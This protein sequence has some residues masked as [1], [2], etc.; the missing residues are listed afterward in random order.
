MRLSIGLLAAL[1]VLAGASVLPAQDVV[2]ERRVALTSGQDI[3]GGDIRQIFGTTLDACI[4][5]CLAETRCVA[6]TFNARSGACFPKSVAGTASPYSGA[7]SGPVIALSGAERN[8]GAARTTELA[9]FLTPDDLTQARSLAAAFAARHPAEGRALPTLRE[10]AEAARA[11]G[12]WQAAADLAA[13]GITLTDD[14]GDW[15]RYALLTRR[16]ALVPEAEDRWGGLQE[17]LSAAINAYLRAETPSA[18]AASLTEL[19]ATLEPMG[20]GR[21]M[22]PALRLAQTL[23]AR[24]ETAAALDEAIGKYGFRLTDTQIDTATDRPRIC[25]VFSEPLAPAGVDYAPFVRLPDPALS[26]EAAGQQLCIGGVRHGER[27]TLTFRR[28]LPSARGEVLRADTPLTA[29][30]RDRSPAAWFPGRAYVLPRTGEVA[31]PV[32]TVNAG[33]LDLVL[34]RVSDRAL[35]R[36]MQEQLFA[37]PL[38]PWRIEDFDAQLAQEIW[39]GTA[40]VPSPLNREITTRLPLAAA[41]PLE[42]GVYVLRAAVADAGDS[43]ASRPQQWFVISDIGV[44]TMTGADGLTVFAQSLGTAEP[45]AGAQV[46]LISQGNAVLAAAE[47]DDTGRAAFALPL[48]RGAGAGAPALLTLRRGEDLS[49]LSLTEP[50][51]DLSDRGVAGREAPPPIDVFLTTDR[52]V[53]RPGE[54]V[55]VTALARNDRA[56][57]ETGLPL[58]LRLTRPDGVEYMRQTGTDQGA[59][60]HVWAAPLGPDAARGLWRIDILAEADRPLTSRTFLVEDFL[61]ERIDVALTLGQ[62]PLRLG[63]VAEG[64]VAARYLFGPPAP[65]LAVEGEVRLR[66]AASL[67]DWPGYRFGLQDDPFAPRMAPLPSGLRTGPDGTLPLTLTLPPVDLPPARPL[68]AEVVLRVAEGSGRPVE[69]RTVA[70]VLPGTPVIGIRPATEGPVPEGGEARYDVIALD[71][72]LTRAALPVRWTLE[73]VETRYQWFNLDSAWNWQ[74][75]TTRAEVAQGEAQIPA[76]APLVLAPRVDWGHYE[77]RVEAADGTPVGTSIGFDAGWYGATEGSG[78]PDRLEVSLDRDVYNPGETA[79]FRISSREGGQA[80]VTVLANRVIASRVVTVPAGGAVVDLA[81]TEDWG[82][83]AYVTASLLRPLDRAAGHNPARAMGLAHAAIA[84]GEKRILARFDMPASADP[85]GPMEAVLRVDGAA[86]GTY[87]TIAAVDLGILNLTGFTP[88]DPEGHYFGQQRLGVGIRDIYGRLIDGLSGALGTIRSGGDAGAQA[89]LQGEPPA[90]APVSFFSGPLPVE[91][92]VVRTGF[93]LPAFNGTVRLMAVIWSE[94]GV[95][96]ATADVTVRDPV[97]VEASAARV[98]APGDESRLLLRFTHAAGAAGHMPLSV[99]ASGL[100]LSSLVP[101]G[102]E[103]AEGGTAEVTLPFSASEQGWARIN[104]ALTTP[105]GRTLSQEVAIPV[106][107]NDPPVSE[108]RRIALDPGQTLRFDRDVFANYVPGTGSA[109]LAAGPQARLD[110]PGLL[111]LLADYPYACT[112]QTASR[113]LPLLYFTET[114]SQMG[115]PP[116]EDAARQAVARI[117]ANQSANGSFGLWQAGSGDLWL[118]AY[119]TDVLLRTKEQGGAVPERALTSALDN[120]RNQLS[121]APDF[122]ARGGPWAYAML[123]LTRAGRAPVDDL[124]YY[125]DVKAAAFDTPL[126]AAQL[127]AALA[128]TGDQSRADRLFAQAGEMAL[129]RLGAPGN[130][131]GRDDYGSDRRDA[132]GMVALAAEAGS[133]AAP[134]DRIVARLGEDATGTA[135]TQ[136]AAWTLLVAHA[137]SA[138]TSGDITVNGAP[139]AGS[140]VQALS[141]DEAATPVTVSNNGGTASLLTLTTFGVPAV[142]EP[143]GGQGYAITRRYTT[144]S[145]E[146]VNGPLAPGTRLVAVI[147]VTPT[148]TVPARLV[149]DDPLPGGLEIDN[150][151]L[152]RAG[153]LSQL[154]WLQPTETVAHAEFRE[155]R[156]VAQ[157][158]S[159]GVEVLRLAYILRAVTPGRYHHPAASV[160]DMYRPDYRAVTDSGTIEVAP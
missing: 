63:A 153:D 67:A 145:G 27:Y 133:R 137:L 150:P 136:E 35:V 71:P 62:A 42:P 127:G 115:L 44:T 7:I 113:L 38:P 119:A 9:A 134:L 16:A 33:R 72:A 3:P 154:D 155:D 19:A 26:V 53:Y 20:R 54:T 142:A 78:T 106:R 143:A 86:P 99:T 96:Q 75:V 4:R 104:V 14:S 25:A 51:F 85:R 55:N 34:S 56:A 28:G 5:A 149:I 47:T 57:A 18:R 60:G 52:G 131:T 147:E 1:G 74:P 157:V 64:R 110:V 41:G 69:R 30:V 97:V 11:A 89:R 39:R 120:L 36:A 68:E 76:D 105:D 156:F 130:R 141:D 139:V 102:I 50:E 126:A 151:N 32:T 15:T 107:R 121:F 144:L 129:E 45:L 43:D 48:L 70:P 158:D 2:P 17:A 91:D 98:L 138:E 58:T 122:D 108:T 65:D 23:D 81:V 83:G 66:A 103:L 88:P 21:D 37:T 114:L 146:P 117:L 135:S 116:A 12:Q 49:F 77:L 118:D 59:G 128:T 148:E 22:I 90:A 10:E 73:R 140:A 109:T 124:R 87:A 159:D 13:Q 100:T 111:K 84:P 79:H 93:D 132:A 94:S 80:L 125:A 160:A 8:R 24:P 29:Y 123:V 31:L 82:T 92:G 40:E 112:E 46:S 152:L 6:M 95:G 61:P 101:E